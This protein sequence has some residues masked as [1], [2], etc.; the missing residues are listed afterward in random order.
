MK[1]FSRETLISLTR[2]MIPPP[3]RYR[4]GSTINFVLENRIVINVSEQACR[5]ASVFM[6]RYALSVNSM[7]RPPP[8]SIVWSVPSAT[9]QSQSFAILVHQD[10]V[11]QNL[12]P[13]TDEFREIQVID[14]SA[15]HSRQCQIFFVD[16]KGA[17]LPLRIAP[18]TSLHGLTRKQL[19]PFCQAGDFADSLYPKATHVNLADIMA[20]GNFRSV[21]FCPARL[22][23]FVG[24]GNRRV[25]PC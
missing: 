12:R 20:Q 11:I 8:K 10:S 13:R 7:P 6:S 9:L 17:G 22:R 14:P 15:L 19:G 4:P 23:E 24:A 1:L 16:P 25:E 3:A 5:T 2:Y 21:S 18:L